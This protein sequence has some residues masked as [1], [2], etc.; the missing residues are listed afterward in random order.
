MH[1]G[2]KS[3]FGYVGLRILRIYIYFYELIKCES[4][5][6]YSY[7]RHEVIVMF[8]VILLDPNEAV[9][10]QDEGTG[11]RKNCLGVKQ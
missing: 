11:G 10:A 6:F 9:L 8:H 7:M 3:T 1:C 2:S 5:L 4:W